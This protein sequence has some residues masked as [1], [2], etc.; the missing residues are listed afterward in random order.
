METM[1]I[2]ICNGTQ[3]WSLEKRNLFLTFKWRKYEISLSLYDKMY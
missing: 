1:E 2:N 3:E